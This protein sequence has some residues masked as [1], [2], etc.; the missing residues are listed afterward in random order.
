MIML[1]TYMTFTYSYVG[2]KKQRKYIQVKMNQRIKLSLF[3][4]FFLASQSYQ[5]VVAIFLCSKISANTLASEIFLIANKN[6]GK[7]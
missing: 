6:S 4:F 7:R 2:E 1:H 3:F 5:T